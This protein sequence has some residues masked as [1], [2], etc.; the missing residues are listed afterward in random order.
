MLSCD[1]L[2]QLLNKDCLTNTGTTE[3]T[4]L[5]TF[6]IRCKKVDNLDTCFQNLY[7]RLLLFE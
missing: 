7:G 5:T 2:N 3:Q 1:V 4:D 6:R